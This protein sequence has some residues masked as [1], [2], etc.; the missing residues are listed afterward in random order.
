MDIATA[1]LSHLGIIGNLVAML[2]KGSKGK[3][4]EAVNSEAE[5]YKSLNGPGNDSHTTQLL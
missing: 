1:E 4:A 2:N 5:I 3:L